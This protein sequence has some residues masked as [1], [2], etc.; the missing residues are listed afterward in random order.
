MKIWLDDIRNPS[1][2]GENDSDWRICR[3][4]EECIG[5]IWLSKQ[6]I[7][8]ISFD[9]DLGLNGGTGNDVALFLEYMAALPFLERCVVHFPIEWGVHSA[10]PVGRNNIIRSMESMDRFLGRNPL[11]QR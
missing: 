11:T 7:E 5:V 10:N 3:T 9:H 1:Y 2:I 4:A 6:P 8:I